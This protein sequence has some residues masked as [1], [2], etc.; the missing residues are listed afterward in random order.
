MKRTKLLM[1]MPIAVEIVGE[2]AAES[3]LAEIFD[4]FQH[5]D[6]VFSTYKKSSEITKINKG[7]P[8]EQWSDE[9]KTVLE[10]CERTKR[11][12]GGYFDIVRG[13]KRDPSGLVKGWAIQNAAKKLA[14]RGR[15]NFY[16]DAGGDIQASGRNNE[17][18]PWRVGIRNPFNRDEIIKTVS[19]G[20]E[21]V[22]TSGTYVRGQHIYDP[23]R[24]DSSPDDIIAITV[25]GPDIYNADRFA[26]AAYA[27]GLRG[28]G[29]I[30]QLPGYEAYMIDH[31]KQA[32]MSSGFERYVAA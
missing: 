11:Q 8:E 22:A 5:V 9:M 4:Y 23:H 25:I 12:T 14:E 15:K 16:I 31:A 28:I 2:E 19:V 13:G 3:D 18:R 10:L 20:S 21:G 6:D 7:L 24:P 17:G 27:M 32:T 1:G 29:F 30:E 26:T